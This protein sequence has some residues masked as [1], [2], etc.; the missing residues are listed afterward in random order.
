M[1]ASTLI[2]IG[3]TTGSLLYSA[4]IYQSGA[5]KVRQVLEELSENSQEGQAQPRT[6]RLSQAEINAYLLDELGQQEQ[7]AVEDVSIL[8]RDGEFVTT[9]GIDP[10]RLQLGENTTAGTLLGLLFEGKQTLEIEG[11]LSVINGIGSYQI[12]QVRFSGMA[13]PREL[14]NEILTSLGRSQDPPFDP[15]STFPI[16]YG[17]QS[18]I[19]SA[20]QVIIAT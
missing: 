1:A 15:T 4:Q 7:R 13:L 5:E 9:V 20:G 17:I 12:Q 14:V 11:R 16:P 6:Y 8:L 18:I 19:V 3:L 10:D 2:W